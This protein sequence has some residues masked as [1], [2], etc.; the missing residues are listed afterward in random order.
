MAKQ[1][2]APEDIPDEAQ[3]FLR[4]SPKLVEE[5][6]ILPDAYSDHHGA[7]STNCEKYSTPEDTRKMTKRGD[8]KSYTVLS[9]NAG[10]IRS[11]DATPQV[12]EH[13]PRNHNRAHTDVIGKK[14]ARVRI[15]FSR[16]AETVLKGE[17]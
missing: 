14:T 11:I 6:I 16:I 10:K 12:V 7:M 1:L 3:L 4:V 17:Q 5:D 2:Y 9:L 8:P 15:Q 13:T